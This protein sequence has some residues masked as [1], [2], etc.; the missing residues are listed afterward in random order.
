[1][2][3]KDGNQGSPSTPSNVFG[4]SPKNLLYWLSEL[5]VEVT[6]RVIST[7]SMNFPSPLRL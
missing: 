7:V 4:I 6:F 2:V 5:Y 3:T 1:M